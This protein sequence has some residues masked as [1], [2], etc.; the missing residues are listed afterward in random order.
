[1]ELITLDNVVEELE[2]GGV[3][4]R[5]RIYHPEKKKQYR[6]TK[7]LFIELSNGDRITMAPGFEWDLS[8]SP[9]LFW[10]IL[11]PDGDFEIAGLIHDYLIRGKKY[12]RKFADREM[13]IWS[14]VVNNQRRWQRIDNQVRFIFVRMFGWIAYNKS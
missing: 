8:S 9:R 1:M 6:L 12:N 7:F 13:L 10:P 4:V 11:P 2:E 14:K 5:E 3:I